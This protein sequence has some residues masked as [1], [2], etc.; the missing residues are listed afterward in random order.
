MLWGCGAERMEASEPAVPPPLNPAQAV[1]KASGT[2]F[3]AVFDMAGLDCGVCRANVG[4]VLDESI[5][6][7]EFEISDNK[8][9][10]KFDDGLNSPENIEAVLES[11]TTSKATLDSVKATDAAE[12]CCPPV[13][14][15]K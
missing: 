5:G 7:Q 13:Q 15:D 3:T 14:P 4:R 9:T 8:L 1:G 2:Q 6:V 12:D 10:V 11:N